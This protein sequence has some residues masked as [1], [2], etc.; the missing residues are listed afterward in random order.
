LKKLI[1]KPQFPI[2]QLLRRLDE[3]DSFGVHMP[4]SAYVKPEVKSEHMSGPILPQF[5]S[6][7]Q[8]NHVKTERWNLSSKTGDNCIL[9]KD[10]TPALIK[11]IIKKENDI[12]VICAKFNAV[13]EAFTYPLNSTKLNICKVAGESSNLFV[14]PL[15]DV[16]YKCVSCPVD[17]GCLV[18]IPL[19][20]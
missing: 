20:H 6:F 18:I 12:S 15:S 1:P 19:L 16:R 4:K 13:D 10:G 3:Q 11:N 14:V 2:Q 17:N 5:I 9:I 7:R 8:F